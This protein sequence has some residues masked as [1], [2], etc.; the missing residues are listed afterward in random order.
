MDLN[1]RDTLDLRV[2][3]TDQYTFAPVFFKA[4]PVHKKPWQT[5]QILPKSRG[6]IKMEHQ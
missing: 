5:F 2:H 6:K 1:P 4:A 3:T